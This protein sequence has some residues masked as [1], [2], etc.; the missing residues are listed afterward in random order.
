EQREIEVTSYAELVLAPPSADLAHPAFS[1]LFVETEHLAGVGALVATRRRR[2][3][4]EPEIWVAHLAVVKGELVGQREF[5]TDRARFLGRAR[6]VR[7]PASIVNGRP[8]SG[9]TGAVLDPIFALRRRVLLE[10]GETARIDFWTV[11]ASSRAEL[12]GL[13]DK[14]HDTAAFE[15]AAALAWTQVQV[16][17]RHL[18]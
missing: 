8:L 3:P 9:T 14:H 1:K 11:A 16:Q 12:L 13:I 4:A 5:E 2:A 7:S 10:P 18:G 15:R 17:L 6:G